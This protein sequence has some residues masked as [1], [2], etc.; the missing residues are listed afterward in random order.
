MATLRG[1]R[2]S[3]A[4]RMIS[5]KGEIARSSVKILLG[6]AAPYV[7]GGRG[8]GA[9]GRLGIARIR[10]DFASDASILCLQYCGR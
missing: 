2:I 9:G 10:R 8:N 6:I 7:G 5:A 1:F 3:G 4:Q